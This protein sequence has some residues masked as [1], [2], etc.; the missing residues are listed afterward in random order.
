MCTTFMAMVL[1][2]TAF[3]Y[4]D[5]LFGNIGGQIR[6]ALKV[7][8]NTHQGQSPGN[9]V[10]FTSHD[11]CQVFKDLIPSLIHDIVPAGELVE[12]IAREAEA[13]LA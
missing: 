9:D 13:L 12:R 11:I 5:N 8:G 3:H 10:F 6:N 2:I 4:I 1:D 7:M